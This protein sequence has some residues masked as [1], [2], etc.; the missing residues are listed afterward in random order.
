MKLA[1]AWSLRCGGQFLDEVAEALYDGGAWIRPDCSFPLGLN[2]AIA[3]RLRA[4]RWQ[5]DQ[6]AISAKDPTPVAVVASHFD[7]LP[8]RLALANQTL[9]QHGVVL[10]LR[11]LPA[12]QVEAWSSFVASYAQTRRA[13]ATGISLLVIADTPPPPDIRPVHW[14][15]RIRRADAGL[16]AEVHALNERA[17]PLG[18]LTHAIAVELLGWRLDLAEVFMRA[19][20]QDVLNPL[21]W[22][23]RREEVAQTGAIF[24]NGR[25]FECPILL[26]RNGHRETLN[27]RLW[28]AHLAAIFPWIE[29]QRQ[30]VLDQYESLLVVSDK[31][32]ETLKVY[33]VRELEISDIARQLKALNV[34]PREVQDS[35]F[36][37]GRIRKALAH[38][39]PA[40]A[41]DLKLAL[42]AV[43]P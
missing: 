41:H 16:W 5:V 28:R 3:D 26:M 18:D 33:E 20:L 29:E 27:N 39:K 36:A 14:H 32:R 23:E 37:M 31:H 30:L 35:Y 19:G 42:Q 9:A 34:V 40:E 15:G 1:E 12:E 10:D 24:F 43:L 25:A 6:L 38:R 7:V 22:L 17:E 2:E 13:E 11:D 21:G 4:E 8:T